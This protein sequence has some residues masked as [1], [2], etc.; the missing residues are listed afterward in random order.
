MKSYATFRRHP[1]GQVVPPTNE[2]VKIWEV[3]P[4]GKFGGGVWSG[5]LAGLIMVIGILI[6]GLVGIPEW[7]Y[8]FG[9]TVLAGSIVAYTLVRKHGQL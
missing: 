9:A 3:V 7:R 2:D 6:V 4:Y 5:N 1:Y 8:F